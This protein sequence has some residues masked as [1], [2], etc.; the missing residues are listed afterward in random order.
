M[1]VHL[2]SRPVALDQYENPNF[3]SND[4]AQ[5]ASDIVSLAKELHSRGWLLGTS[6]NLSAV[7]DR[8]P[9][10]LAI[11]P[12]GADKG[13]LSADQILLIDE[14]TS[15]VGDADS[16]AGKPSDE[17]PLHVAIVKTQNAGAVIHTHSVWATVLSEMHGD[18][19]GL[20]IEAYEMLK[21]LSG[22]KTHQHREWI[23]ILDNSQDMP[24]LAN[25]IT[26]TLVMYPQSHA[27]ML[28]RHGMYTWGRNLKEAQRHV[29]ILEF[30]LEAVGRTLELRVTTTT[31]LSDML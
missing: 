6:G 24:A 1:A 9:L 4:F 10:R 3:M 14:D 2:D 15:V 28:R 27:I 17:S 16:I 20:A 19:G 11:T 23:P 8:G 30:L 22:I 31:R 29:E 7:V 5:L 21:G 13:K 18:D 26:E 25:E 12:S